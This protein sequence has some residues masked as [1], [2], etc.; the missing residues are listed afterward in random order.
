PIRRRPNGW[1]A[2]RCA[3]RTRPR[4]SAAT[5]SGCCGCDK[6]TAELL[7]S[8]F[9][10]YREINRECI[11]FRLRAQI[12]GLNLQTKFGTSGKIPYATEQGIFCKDQGI[13]FLPNMECAGRTG[14]FATASSQTC[15]FEPRTHSGWIHA[16]C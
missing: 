8:P 13:T 10:G 4:S 3:T 9:P 16:R 1:K 14:N 11:Q 7:C 5:P 6:S 2:C 12:S 15:S